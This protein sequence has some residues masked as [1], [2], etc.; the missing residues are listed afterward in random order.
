MIHD[1]NRSLEVGDA[2]EQVIIDWLKSGKN[3]LAVVDLRKQ[4]NCQALDVD[5]V[6]EMRYT[7]N[8]E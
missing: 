3:T 2:G 5:F 8:T 4:P 7:K 6:L 1:F